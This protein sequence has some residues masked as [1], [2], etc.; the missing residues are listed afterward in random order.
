M[1]ILDF[2][3]AVSDNHGVIRDPSISETLTDEGFGFES[4]KEMEGTTSPEQNR[5]GGTD[6]F[7]VNRS[8]TSKVKYC[9]G[10]KS[11]GN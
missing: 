5:V 7:V 11:L 3:H 2:S 10:M 8:K 9:L 4:N 6:S 1:T